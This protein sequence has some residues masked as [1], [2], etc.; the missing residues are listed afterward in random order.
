MI[1]QCRLDDFAPRDWIGIHYQEPGRDLYDF[2]TIITSIKNR[3]Q[4]PL[5]DAIEVS[6]VPKGCPKPLKRVYI[7][8]IWHVIEAPSIDGH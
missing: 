3:D 8:R 2:P 4:N 7:Q 6:H 1:E 5:E